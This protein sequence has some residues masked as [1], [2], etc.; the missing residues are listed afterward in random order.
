MDHEGKTEGV[1]HG[2]GFLDGGRV[3][4]RVTLSRGG[5][6]HPAS[7]ARPASVA[8]EARGRVL[9]RIRRAIAEGD[10]AQA[11]QIARELERRFDAARTPRATALRRGANRQG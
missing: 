1:L 4:R 2:D 3:M 6:P 11:L 8:P 9:E 5:A 10:E 7:T